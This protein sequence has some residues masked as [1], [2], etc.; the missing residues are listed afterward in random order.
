MKSETC[1][2]VD[3]GF[4]CWI[5]GHSSPV[6]DL[7]AVLLCLKKKGKGFYFCFVFLQSSD[8]FPPK[9]L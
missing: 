5:E 9:M 1:G 3:V 7:P 8:S 4:S 2:P 6:F